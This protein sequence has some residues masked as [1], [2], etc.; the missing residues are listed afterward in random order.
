MTYK[1]K[2][3]NEK[4]SNKINHHSS[5][6]IQ[7]LQKSKYLVIDDDM[8]RVKTWFQLNQK[9]IRETMLQSEIIGGGGVPLNK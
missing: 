8:N 6:H 1:H 2:I 9:N 5:N 3:V 7:T 4:E